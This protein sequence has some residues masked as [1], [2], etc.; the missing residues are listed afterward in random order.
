MPGTNLDG[1]GA[2]RAAVQPAVH[3]PELARAE[4]LVRED[5]V[6]LRHLCRARTR[7]RRAA[8]RVRAL[9]WGYILMING[10]RSSD[11]FSPI[12]FRSLSENFLKHF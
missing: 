5:L 7:A 2:A 11:H 9:R 1:D 8:A 12:C 10:W 4:H 6:H 3:D